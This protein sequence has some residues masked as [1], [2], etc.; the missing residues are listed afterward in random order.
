MGSSASTPAPAVLLLDSESLIISANPT[1]A[2]ILGQT[3]DKLAGQ[4]LVSLL[5]FE[6]M[7]DDPV[8]R[9]IQW[10]ALC[11]TASTRPQSIRT[12]TSPR[13][14]HL[15][16]DPA[17]KDPVRWFATLLPTVEDTAE[18]APAH[19]LQ[20][21]LTLLANRSAL[22]FFDLRLD[23]GE[24]TTS[25]GWK[26]MLGYTE[27]ELPDT[28]A[29]WRRFV[30]PDDT[31]AA[32]DQITKRQPPGARPFANEYRLRHREGH[33]LWVSCAGI[34]VFNPDGALQRV[35]G[36]HIDITDRKELEEISLLSDERFHRLV[37]QG[38]LAAFDLDFAEGQH[39]F[40]AAWHRVLGTTPSENASLPEPT[41]LLNALPASAQ[42]AGLTAFFKS[43]QPEPQEE[44]QV[45]SLTNA[46]G[47]A[48][49]LLLGYQRDSTKRGELLRVTGYALPL[50]GF[51]VSQGGTPP[52]LQQA[53]LD[54]LAECVI[55]TDSRAQILNLNAKAAIL[56]GI[57][58]RDAAGR[59]LTEVFQLIDRRTGQPASDAIQLALNHPENSRLCDLH[60]ISPAPP[61]SQ[62]HPIVWTLQESRNAE[63]ARAGF[64]VVFRDPEEMTLSPEE[65]IQANRSESLGLL[66]G[67]IA[68]DFNN[69][70]TTIL[71]GVSTAKESRDF[72]Q[73]DA[74][75]QACL[76][77]KQLTRQLLSFAK[78]GGSHASRHVVNLGDIL[79]NAV[80][81]AAAGSP[82]VV[83]VQ[84]AEDIT[85]VEV[86]KG[87]MIQVIQNLVLNAL[88]AMPVPSD[89]RVVVRAENIELAENEFY[90]L[91][92]G[93][94]AR[95]DVE[96]NGAGIPEDILPHIF[97]PFFTTKKT[98]TGLGLATV[99]SIV[100]RHGGRIGVES[101]PAKGTLFSMFL[102]AAVK[103][104]QAESR[105]SPSLRF[106]TGRV[107]LMDDDPKI[108]ELTG[109]MIASLDYTH[110]VARNGEEALQLYRRYQNV[111]RPYDA[112][113]LDLTVI[114]GMGGEE[115]FRRLRAVDPD[116]RAIVTSGYDD[117]DM[118]K[119]FLE[120]GFCGYLT[121]P[122]RVSE[123]ARMLK[124]VLGR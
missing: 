48:I 120:M 75:E 58:A 101:T 33:Y 92:R 35:C 65:L 38:G 59:P 22:G 6:L 47:E 88:Q 69:L 19:P 74:A 45:V 20:D 64:I 91:P 16:L 24:I 25:T 15:R 29:S 122:Y 40:S 34:R 54:A 55:I 27:H 89:G 116:V 46:K 21:A 114:G 98:G 118:I 52:A 56:T 11:A 105:R 43:T 93:L 77:A 111:N 110:D 72:N 119:R 61:G 2:S 124:T 49:P 82:V 83:K 53:A 121:K 106:G 108:C 1:A 104:M 8:M 123:L 103:P 85:P 44:H 84:T 90:D 109:A 86:D 81:I 66:A 39:W 62:A 12:R 5:H 9:T 63:G 42:A 112:V 51:A 37:T 57:P 115:C 80:R 13:L 78:G 18:A 102:P 70:L 14:F 7:S 36:L 87:Q 28:L 10:E 31:T 3:L 68:H 71:G 30:H 97:D 32:P 76:A 26:R 67:G 94:Y 60:A 23:A 79:Q 117:D 17:S 50:A 73:L 107:L 96:D 95:I 99:D 100:R 113:L 4:S 41:P